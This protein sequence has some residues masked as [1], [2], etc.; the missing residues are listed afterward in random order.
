[1]NSSR[2]GNFWS[3]DS[4]SYRLQDLQGIY[5]S[6]PEF[7]RDTIHSQILRRQKNV[8]TLHKKTLDDVDHRNVSIY[9]REIS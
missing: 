4:D 9:G 1:M 6:L 5:N 3:V 7:G 8:V 2:F